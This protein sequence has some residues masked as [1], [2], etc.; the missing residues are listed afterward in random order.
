MIEATKIIKKPIITEKTLLDAS[1]G[2]Y[3]FEVDRNANKYEIAQAVS[4][5]FKVDV[6]K[7]KTSIVKN[8]S[9][10]VL[11][12]RQT[13]TLPSFKK[14]IVKLGKDQKIDIFEVKA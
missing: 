7:V 14:A 4:E 2:E 8:R 11:R 3:T 10:R 5:V 1:V 12:T 9:K 13:T 6:K